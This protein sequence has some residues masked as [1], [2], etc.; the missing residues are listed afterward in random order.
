MQHRDKQR[1]RVEGPDCLLILA[2]LC[3]GDI[4]LPIVWDTNCLKG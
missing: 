4:L 2:L 1:I 3:R